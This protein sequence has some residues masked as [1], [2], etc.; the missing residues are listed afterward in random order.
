MVV[1]IALGRDRTWVI[2]QAWVHTFTVE[3][4]LVGA[5]LV[6]RRALALE[7]S[8]LGVSRVAWLARAHTV[9]IHDSAVRVLAT[10]ARAATQ[11]VDT[12]LGWGT[13]RVRRAFGGRV[14][15]CKELRGV[16][17]WISV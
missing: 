14:R 16:L 9:V 2:D 12:R 7:A 15:S 4:L 5:A 6:V 8:S 3:A 1:A 17:V 11:T 13:V 10:Q